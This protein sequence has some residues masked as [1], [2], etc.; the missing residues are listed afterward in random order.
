M[1]DPREQNQFPT[2]EQSVN[3]SMLVIRAWAISIEVFLRGTFGLRALGLPALF[4]L[5]LVPIFSMFWP[6]DDLDWTLG[7]LGWYLLR[8]IT[9]RLRHFFGR[10]NGQHSYYSG[11]PLLLRDKWWRF[12][13]T[14]KRI[15]EPL[16]V[17]ATGMYFHDMY[18]ASFGAYLMIGAFC[19]F[20]SAHLGQN[21]DRAHALNMRDALLEQ[22]SLASHYQE[23][24]GDR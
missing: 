7:F 19:M 9:I 1:S 20:M 13:I 14:Y 22:Q 21:F 12:E 2:F 16:I 18:R 11:Y 6:I 8:C 17:F 4:V 5:F 24:F 23:R 3:W 15:V 10:D